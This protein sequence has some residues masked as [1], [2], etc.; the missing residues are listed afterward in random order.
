MV[1]PMVVGFFF[2]L[3]VNTTL[4]D[5]CGISEHLQSFREVL[6]Q[7]KISSFSFVFGVYQEN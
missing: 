6:V 5:R 4:G 2:L 7:S 1:N 3:G